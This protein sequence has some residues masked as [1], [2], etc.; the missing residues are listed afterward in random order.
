MSKSYLVAVK[1]FNKNHAVVFLP[2][3]IPNW[4]VIYSPA[5]NGVMSINRR[6]SW[7]IWY[8]GNPNFAFIPFL[9]T[10][11]AKNIYFATIFNYSFVRNFKIFSNLVFQNFGWNEIFEVFDFHWYRRMSSLNY[12]EFH[13]QKSLPK[14]FSPKIT[15]I[16]FK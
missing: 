3:L 4:E 10:D 6:I 15:K 14:E 11:I 9:L 8:S 16:I 1:K 13:F 5:L 2:P 12:L 7:K